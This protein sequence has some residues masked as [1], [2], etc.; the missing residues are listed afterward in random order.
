M[1]DSENAKR[2]GIVD[3]IKTFNLLDFCSILLKN[4][5]LII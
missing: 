4:L 3:R 5:L 1:I 2:K